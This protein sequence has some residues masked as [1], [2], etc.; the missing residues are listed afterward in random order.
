MSL[1]RNAMDGD[2]LHPGFPPQDHERHG[3][4]GA[5]MIATRA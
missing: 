2:T 4:D 3:M 1:L 5:V